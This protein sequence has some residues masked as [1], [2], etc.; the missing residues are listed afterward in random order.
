M[1]SGM[2]EEGLVDN[3][4]N[5]T[6]FVWHTDDASEVFSMPFS[7]ATGAIE[8]VNPNSE[9]LLIDFI[10]KPCGQWFKTTLNI[11]GRQEFSFIKLYQLMK[12]AF[13][14]EF[15]QFLR[16]RENFRSQYRL[17]ADY[18]KN[19]VWLHRGLFWFIDLGIFFLAYQLGGR[20]ERFQVVLNSFLDPQIRIGAHIALT[21][22]LLNCVKAIL[23]DNL[24]DCGTCRLREDHA[25]IN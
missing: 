12:V 21:Q 18:F 1:R 16:H 7:K 19:L 5:R 10:L 13:V 17:A 4:Q 11:S 8:R 2:F 9:V 6:I 23:L 15:S 14:L 22:P 25:C 24:A 3:S 20:K